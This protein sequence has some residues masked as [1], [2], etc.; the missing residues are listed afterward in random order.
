M[1]GNLVFMVYK[2]ITHHF[3]GL[4]D[5]LRK[6][7]DYRKVKNYEI[8]ELIMA[9][10]AMFIFKEGSR[11]AFN[12]DRKEK[13]F[14]KNY[15]RIFKAR[16]PHMDTVDLIMRALDTVQI[17]KVKNVLVSGLIEKKVFHKYRFLGKYYKV[18]VD[19]T[20]VMNVQKGH[21]E[22]CLHRTSK[23]G[24][25]TYFHN[26]LE[27][28]LICGNGFCI[29]LATEW[30][31]N[32]EGPYD[33]QDCE[34][35][36]FARLASKLKHNFSRLNI[37]VVADGLYPNSSFF[38]IC[39]ENT[40]S[41]IVT[42]KDGNLPT[43]WEDVFGLQ[44]IT[45]NNRRKEIFCKN[46]H[47]IYRQYTWINSVEYSEFHLNWF[48]CVEDVGDVRTRFVYVSDLE[49]NWQTVLEMTESGRMRWKIENEG[50]NIQ[51]NNGY[52]LKHKFSRVS[53]KAV[54]NYY[55]CMQ[56]AHMINQ[57]F[58]LGSL[59]KPI[60]VGKMTIKHVWKKMLGELRENTLNV[61]VLKE[62]LRWKTQ[63]RFT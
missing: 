14:K 22:H 43:V 25:V 56:I 1:N 24:K 51:K 4:F 21:C 62:L 60:L 39:K 13:K 8:A 31:E 36:A 33:K 11:N 63:I 57:F 19:G 5:E 35:K 41:W 42:F 40:W 18:A 27:A 50:F 45:D 44:K 23:N 58:E 30:I 61:G 16:L 46:G 48:E 37:C 38:K 3:P 15:R 59:L 12:N 9:C 20:H 55:Q 2:T 6:I 29:S 49:V 53:M 52:G 28:K 17:E 7:E 34:Q 10:I 54:K 26:V 47:K 32:P